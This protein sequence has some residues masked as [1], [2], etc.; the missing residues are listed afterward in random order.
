MKTYKKNYI[1]K[2]TQHETLDLVKVTLKVEELLKYQHEYEGEMYI[3]F[4]VAKMQ[5]VDKFGRTHTVYVNTREETPDE[6]PKP[7][8]RGRK[9]K[10]EMAEA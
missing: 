6:N 9:P 8:K 4:E 3:S 1:G 5:N 10:K 2:G 7:K